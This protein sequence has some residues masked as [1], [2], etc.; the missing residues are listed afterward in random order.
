MPYEWIVEAAIVPMPAWLLGLITTPHQ[1]GKGNLAHIHQSP[2]PIDFD[3]AMRVSEYLARCEPAISG[4][5]GH[6]RTICRRRDRG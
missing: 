5:H 1:N 3:L 6:D 2:G 4:Q